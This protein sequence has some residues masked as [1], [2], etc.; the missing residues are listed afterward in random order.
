LP[1]AAAP[2]RRSRRRFR[3]RRQRRSFGGRRACGRATLAR[4][5][6]DHGAD[7]RHVAHFHLDL[8]ERTGGDRRH[9]HRNLVGLDLEQVVA[10]LHGIAGRLEPLGDLALGDSFAELR[11]QYIHASLS[12]RHH[13][14]ARSASP[15]DLD[16]IGT[17]AW[18]GSPGQARR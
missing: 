13:R 1:S 3:R 5:D 16:S 7:K 11:H 8:G 18:S 15:G 6:R 12:T 17:P 10:R 4:D 9:L 2:R 14:A